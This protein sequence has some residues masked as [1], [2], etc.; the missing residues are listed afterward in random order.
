MVGES[1]PSIA[2][3]G[4]CGGSRDNKDR[5]KPEQPVEAVGGI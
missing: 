5:Q 2:E 3:G 1:E 4:E